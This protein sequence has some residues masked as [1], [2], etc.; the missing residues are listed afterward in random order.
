MKSKSIIEQRLKEAAE[1]A[2]DD[3]SHDSPFEVIY[4][5]VLDKIDKK[6]ASVKLK[7]YKSLLSAMVDPL[8]DAG[9]NRTKLLTAA[10]E[11]L[12]DFNKLSR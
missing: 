6:P 9:A 7:L 12:K 4:K 1:V 5:K 10:R 3:V 11:F 8:A 2:D